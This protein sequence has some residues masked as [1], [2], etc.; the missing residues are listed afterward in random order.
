MEKKKWI[1][2]YYYFCL[3]TVP[4]NGGEETTNGHHPSFP[5]LRLPPLCAH[6]FLAPFPFLH[7]CTFSTDLNRERLLAPHH[8][9]IAYT[10]YTRVNLGNMRGKSDVACLKKASVVHSQASMDSQACAI[11]AGKFC[12]CFDRS[13]LLKKKGQEVSPY[14]NGRCIFLVGMMGSGKTTV[15][16]VL[17]ESLGYSF[18]DSDKFIEQAMGET[19]VAQIIQQCGETFFREYESEA[20]RRL[21]LT[22]GHVIATGGG[23]VVRTIN[24]KYMKQGITVWLDV[25]LDALARRIA[26]VGTDSRPLLDF[27]SGDAYT[28]AF[29]GLF[30]LSKKR[31]DSY[32]NSDTTV[33]FQHI[34]DKLGLED[35]ADITPTDIAIEV[36]EQIG[37]FLGGNSGI[38][39]QMYP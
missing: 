36:L 34:A 4:K 28:K 24:W 32:A 10:L 25:P 13:W 30:T 31:A 12:A 20:L 2:N 17:A 37:S 8:H 16:K 1:K 9:S 27:E 3:T 22:S 15:G 38:S 14:L 6:F 23:A 33:S 7:H 29:M 18:V 39:I 26:A 21:S 35:I 5:L 11:E 19:S